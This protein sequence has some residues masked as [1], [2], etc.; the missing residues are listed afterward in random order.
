MTHLPVCGLFSHLSVCCCSDVF[1]VSGIDLYLLKHAERH[2][3]MLTVRAKV[4]ALKRGEK[5][6]FTTG[7]D[8]IKEQGVNHKFWYFQASMRHERATV[9]DEL[10]I[11]NFDRKY[12]IIIYVLSCCRCQHKMSFPNYKFFIKQN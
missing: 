6:M 10:L 8:K 4:I 12:D 11:F 3:N 1:H 5:T 9:S 2:L 7:L